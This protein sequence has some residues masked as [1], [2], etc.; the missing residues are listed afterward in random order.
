MNICLSFKKKISDRCNLFCWWCCCCVFQLLS[1]SF[2][3]F[4]KTISN[5]S[6]WAIK[7]NCFVWTLIRFACELSKSV[8]TQIN[9]TKKN[10]K[11]KYVCTTQIQVNDNIKSLKKVGYRVWCH[12]RHRGDTKRKREKKANQTIINWI[13]NN[14]LANQ[15]AN[16]FIF[17][18]I[19]YSNHSG[20]LL[21][22]YL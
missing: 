11:K 6:K 15:V 19:F 20:S 21:F 5:V 18:L 4:T 2:I 14:V 8:G 9:Q 16:I 17:L 1:I 12:D 13:R 7:S 22:K 3:R 10:T